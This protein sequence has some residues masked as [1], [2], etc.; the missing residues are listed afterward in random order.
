MGPVSRHGAKLILTLTWLL[1]AHI[2][3]AHGFP[4]IMAQNW[5]ELGPRERYNAL[6]NYWRHERLPP[7]RQRD[8]EKRYERWQSMSPDERNRIRQNYERYR[9][10]PP[11]E[12]E[13]A[14]RRYD[15]WVQQGGPPPPPQ[16]RQEQGGPPP[17][18]QWRRQQ[19][20]PPPPP[21]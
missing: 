6:Q 19:G 18:P 21:H 5:R 11:Q 2:A 17:P 12:R 1:S 13:R 7:D 10:L 3:A 16:W 9:Q 14:Q 4:M 15:K 20:G 8:V